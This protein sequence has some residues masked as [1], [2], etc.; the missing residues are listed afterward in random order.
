MLSG[1]GSPIPTT[2]DHKNTIV[3]W[4]SWLQSPSNVAEP[5]NPHALVASGILYKC[6]S[7]CQSPNLRNAI[8]EYPQKPVAHRKR[9]TAMRMHGSTIHWDTV[10]FAGHRKATK[11]NAGFWEPP[12]DSTV[13]TTRE[14]PPKSPCFRLLLGLC[15][16]W[17]EYMI[18]GVVHQST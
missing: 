13:V 1:E 11:G 3:I 17:G 4:A 18:T 9:P 8:P 14:G 7:N 16:V 12:S 6:I 2:L 5:Q 15:E 10:P